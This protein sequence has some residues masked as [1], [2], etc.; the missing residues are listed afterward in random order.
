MLNTEL[1]AQAAR[2]RRLAHGAVRLLALI[3]TGAPAR[4]NPGEVWSKELG[5]CSVQPWKQQLQKHGYIPKP[6]RAGQFQKGQ[7]HH[8][9]ENTHTPVCACETT[10]QISG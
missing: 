3:Q 5:V 4:N 2:D 10:G 8:D 9:S 1:I 6:T 7:N